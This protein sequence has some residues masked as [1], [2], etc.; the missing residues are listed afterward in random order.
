MF[1]NMLPLPDIDISKLDYRIEADYNS[2]KKCDLAFQDEMLEYSRAAISAH[3]LLNIGKTST[4]PEFEV[5]S[6][7]VPGTDRDWVINCINGKYSR[8]A[9]SVRS[10]IWPFRTRCWSSVGG[11][12]STPATEHREDL[13]QARV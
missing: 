3:L 2:E 11:H 5:E 13:Y 7:G 4:K 8:A 9:M 6:D 1:Q 10:V 12:L